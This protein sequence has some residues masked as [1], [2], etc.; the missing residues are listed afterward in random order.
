[1]HSWLQFGQSKQK[2]SIQPF[3]VTIRV[4]ANSLQ[5]TALVGDGLKV[6]CE[7]SILGTI[8]YSDYDSWKTSTV[9]ERA[10]YCRWWGV[11][12]F[13]SCGSRSSVY[14]ICSMYEEASK[15]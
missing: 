10:V 7:N 11:V 8:P 5:V 4:T 12:L 2:H 6:L 9:A 1:M 14:G 15:Q 3:S 13:H